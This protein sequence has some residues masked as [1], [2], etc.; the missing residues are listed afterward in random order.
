MHR[1]IFGFWLLS[2]AAACAH[3]LLAGDANYPLVTGF[4][5]FYSSQDPDEYLVQGG[6]LLLNE[7]NCVG[8][9]P[10]A[11]D[12]VQRLPGVKGPGLAGAGS[13]VR[14][15][16]ALQLMIR[17]P[18][19]LKRATT[20][21]TLF[22]AF[23]RDEEE[24]DALFQYLMS[25][26]EPEQGPML[27]GEVEQGRQIY[28]GVGC[29]ACHEPDVLY[30]P[31]GWP[32]DQPLER[33]GM[34]SLPI[35]WVEYWTADFVTRFLMEP[36]RFHPA[37]RMPSLGLSEL[38]AAHVTAYL[39]EYGPP[40]LEDPA[41]VVPDAGLAER[42]AGL[43]QAKGCS[44]CHDVNGGKVRGRQSV[45]LASLRPGDEG[46]LA[47][48]PRPGGIPFYF[49]SELQKR[50]L[51]AAL[52]AVQG[53][54]AVAENREVV[55]ETED[56]LLRMDCYACHSFQGKGGPELARE[57]YFGALNPSA[58]DRDSWLPPPLEDLGRDCRTLVRKTGDC[59]RR[60]G[61]P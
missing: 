14:D 12:W 61:I 19:V 26:K 5:R 3:P 32:A 52:G 48:E 45:A 57:P 33:P 7:L 28:H 44:T 27:A 18:R 2:A 21:P 38:E 24:L 23:D 54:S 40:V 59:L 25:L 31:P 53:I 30:V 55:S 49:L 36:R 8:C 41:A 10:P 16:G 35:R 4:D 37:G 22:A 60:Q 20:M 17:N 11:G 43:F 50:A 29:V 46:C 13:R 9:H 56:F 42:G 39:Q 6:L 47:P 58:P 51:R 15:A 1:L 34:A